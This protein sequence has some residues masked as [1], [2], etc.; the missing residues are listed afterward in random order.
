M[1][2]ADFEEAEGKRA[3]PT[4]RPARLAGEER[5]GRCDFVRD[6]RSVPP[7]F[8]VLYRLP[9]QRDDGS[10]SCIL[11]TV[12]S[13]H[14]RFTSFY[15]HTVCSAREPY[16]VIYGN[17]RILAHIIVRASKVYIY[18]ISRASLCATSCYKQLFS[19]LVYVQ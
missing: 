14:W 2:G 15:L 12:Y 16:T 7:A 13:P 8:S 18:S 6:E 9:W 10:S 5:P 17:V 4:R 1:K 19:K 3:D 11:H